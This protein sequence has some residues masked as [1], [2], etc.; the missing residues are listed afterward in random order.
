MA[1]VSLH[2]HRVAGCERRR[3][4]ASGDRKGEGKITRAEDRDRAQRHQHPPQIGPGKRLAGR[5]RRVDPG[6]DPGAFAR[7]GG[8]HPELV[9]GAGAFARQSG[10]RQCRLEVGSL[11][12]RV[13]EGDDFIGDPL[14]QRG[15]LFSAGARKDRERLL[16]EPQ[17]LVDVGGAGDM[18]RAGE[19]G[20]IERARDRERLARTAAERLAD[21][22]LS[23]QIHGRK[24]GW[25][26][27]AG[28]RTQTTCTRLTRRPIPLMAISTSSLASSVNESGGTMP[29]PVSST[30]PRGKRWLRKR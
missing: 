27:K 17:R 30:A 2:D 16:R 13:S 28:E 1:L 29:V 7:D 6:I 15:A 14:E 25:R 18:K 5:L 9:G 8:K 26:A 19:Q 20:L 22:I 11:E 3:G 12:K 10:G 23:V 24:Q 4:V 21:E